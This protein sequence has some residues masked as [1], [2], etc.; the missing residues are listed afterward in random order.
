MSDEPNAEPTQQVDTKRSLCELAGI[1][2]DEEAEAMRAAIQD[3]RQRDA[4][5]ADRVVDLPDS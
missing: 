4:E 5:A 3:R 1:L 2:T